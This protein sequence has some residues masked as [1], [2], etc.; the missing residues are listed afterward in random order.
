MLL[1][2]FCHNIFILLASVLFVYA[3]SPLEL[4]EVLRV[5]L[6]SQELLLTVLFMSHHNP[7][8]NA[9]VERPARQQLSRVHPSLS[10]MHP[11]GNG[12]KFI[13][14]EVKLNSRGHYNIKKYLYLDGN[15]KDQGHRDR[16]WAL[17]TVCC[18]KTSE[19]W[20]FPGSGHC[21]LIDGESWG[22]DSDH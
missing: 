10:L 8:N 1:S 4:L 22:P 12:R 9:M 17:R 18:R 13:R 3:F 14:I 7:F 16:C 5:C 6:L 19:G 21:A 2:H 11:L 20:A 15:Q